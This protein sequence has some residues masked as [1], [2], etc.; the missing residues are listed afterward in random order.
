MDTVIRHIFLVL[1]CLQPVVLTFE[2]YDCETAY[3]T[4]QTSWTP[5]WK[6]W[7]CLNHHRGCEATHT[8]TSTTES[9]STTSLTTTTGTTT[10]MTETS[11]TSSRTIST[12]T[13]STQTSSTVTTAT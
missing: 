8:H 2:A 12:M 1:A 9:T 11:S 5:G 3:A 10:T 13:S 6:A 4:W 7:C